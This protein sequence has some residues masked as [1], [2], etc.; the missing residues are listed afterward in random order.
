MKQSFWSLIVLSTLI[1]C[2]GN[3][4]GDVLSQD[5]I[6]FPVS[7]FTINPNKDTTI[8]GEQGTR[9]FI[10]SGTFQY[11]DGRPAVDSIR[12]ELK[13]FYEMADIVLADLNTRSDEKILETAGMIHIDV[14]SNTEKLEIKP[15][16]QIVVHF[17]RNGYN[18]MNLFYADETATDS[19]VSNWKVDTVSLVKKTVKLGSYG[20]WYPGGDDSTSYDFIPK[21]FVDTGYYWNPIDFYVNA[22]DFS[23]ATK[24]EIG[25]NMN[26]NDYPKFES[27]NDFGIE[28][29]MHIS[30][31]GYITNPKV[32]SN[33]SKA[34][35]Q[36]IITFLKKL[37]QLEPGVNKNGEIIERRGLMFIQSGAI[38]PL[39]Q[40]DEEYLKSFN[41]KYAVYE[42][43]AIQNVD[44]AELDY[45]I[46]SVSKLGWINCDRF[47]EMEQTLD[48]IVDI[49]FDP[50]TNFKMVFSDIDG[51]LKADVVNNQYVF[52]KV[53]KD[54]YVTLIGMKE[55]N[56][57]L[58]TAFKKLP[59]TNQ[60]VVEWTFEETTLSKLREQLNAL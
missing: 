23:D 24:K 35:K 45:Y 1:A 43:T 44:D 34:T 18:E 16:K 36:E 7:N 57:K 60:P 53:P 47:I 14:Y 21:D 15:G 31:E 26:K 8:F 13:E 52:K 37:P 20:W 28:C 25:S 48:M 49:P 39:Y 4:S 11:K 10:G 19:S 32:N 3:K 50:G 5:D 51:V 42:N 58:L 55:E 38:V 46:F 27:W 2:S 59:I 6:Q 56:G 9:I 33:V 17:P 12:I 54:R 22:Y 41:D 30:T 29:E 40:T